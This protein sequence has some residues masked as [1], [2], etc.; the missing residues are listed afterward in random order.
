MNSPSFLE[1]KLG[2][3]FPKLKVSCSRFHE[4]SWWAQPRAWFP[5]LGNPFPTWENQRIA[6][7]YTFQIKKYGRETT[8]MSDYPWQPH[9]TLPFCDDRGI[10][11]KPRLCR[12]Q[13][14]DFRVLNADTVSHSCPQWG[15]RNGSPGPWGDDLIH[16][17]MSM[18]ISILCEFITVSF[19]CT[20]SCGT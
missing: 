2:R 1:D 4:K 7:S 5:R 6:G 13:Q 9:F 14:G 8:H 17:P 3:G 20:H 12:H 19:P 16:D 15:G 11:T 18:L 10:E